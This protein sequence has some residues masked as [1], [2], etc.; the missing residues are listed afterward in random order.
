MPQFGSS[1]FMHD[2]TTPLGLFILIGLTLII[3]SVTFAIYIKS[4]DNVSQ[5]KLE[6][7]SKPELGTKIKSK[8]NNRRNVN[9]VWTPLLSGVDYEH[10]GRVE[11]NNGPQHLL[12]YNPLDATGESIRGIDSGSN[13]FV[14][15]CINGGKL[16]LYQK[17]WLTY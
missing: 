14:K 2:I 9:L 1:H 4:L 17:I 15:V 16:R 10:N 8:G 13:Q 12:F 5:P 3:V 7:V 6:N 11:T